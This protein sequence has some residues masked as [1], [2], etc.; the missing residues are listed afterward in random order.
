MNMSPEEMIRK[1]G[2]PKLAIRYLA[3]THWLHGEPEL[4]LLPYL[5]SNQ[6][7]SLDIGAHKGVYT[8]FMRKYSKWCHAFEPNPELARELQG[9]FKDRV[10]IHNCAISDRDDPIM[11]RMPVKID[12][13]S[14]SGLGTV[15]L[16][17]SL[18]G[19]PTRS[20]LVE[21]KRL[22]DIKLGGDV[23][24]CVK[25]DVEGHE[26]SVLEGATQIVE[27][28][29]PNF[30]VEAED[31]HKSGTITLMKRFFESYEYEGFFLLNHKLHP[32]Y[33]FIPEAHQNPKA[34][35]SV[36]GK[37]QDG[38]VYINNY[39]FMKKPIKDPR[40]ASLCLKEKDLLNL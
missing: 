40:V 12:G 24:G 4:R 22:D 14:L 36:S 6:K 11:L 5:C 30:I 32:I 2:T 1:L 20:I 39:V 33:D 17:N 7:I 23:V 3:L 26:I 9:S 13:K 8:Y 28:Y 21:R 25:I 18:E 27:R 34:L 19:F 15:E 29:H 31:R 37:R 16:G 35:D 10:V 38:R